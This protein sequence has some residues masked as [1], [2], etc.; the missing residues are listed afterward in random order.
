M[1]PQLRRSDS[2]SQHVVLVEAIRLTAV[3]VITMLY[4]LRP[5]GTR[6]RD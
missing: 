5:L 2:R 1:L 3:E 4:L 6:S